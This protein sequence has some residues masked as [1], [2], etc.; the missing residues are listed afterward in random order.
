M[1]R[2]LLSWEHGD[3]LYHVKRLEVLYRALTERGH[4]CFLACSDILRAREAVHDANIP[5]LQAP[6]LPDRAQRFYREGKP[7]HSMADILLAAGYGDSKAV[8]ATMLS[9]QA[10]F[11]SLQVDLLVSDYSPCM[12]LASADGPPTICIGDGFTMPFIQNGCFAEFEGRMSRESRG[13]SQALVG[14]LKELVRGSIREDQVLERMTYGDK[15]FCITYDIFDHGSKPDLRNCIGPIR[16]QEADNKEAIPREYDYFAYLSLDYQ[17]TLPLLTGIKQGRFK[18]IAYLRDCPT[19]LR[20]ELENSNLMIFERP[21]KLEPILRR[22]KAVIHHGGLGTSED[23][24]AAGVPQLLVP[25]HKEQILNS[26]ALL[27]HGC[28]VAMQPNGKFQPEHAAAALEAL[29][30]RPH[31]HKTAKKIS[32]E[33]GKQND[34]L[35]IIVKACEAALIQ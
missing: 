29:L 31:F 5:I 28:A 20:E 11:N 14:Q 9:W 35:G 2:I 13:T 16:T 30:S 15:G 6:H 34:S 21:Q 17:G 7:I 3:G 4:S 22:V 10:L 32:N 18:G 26:Q 27:E 25:R 12:N 19:Q 8:Q 1:G 33:T 23:C 24:L